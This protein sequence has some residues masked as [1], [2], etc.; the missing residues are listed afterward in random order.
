MSVASDKKVITL[1]C[2]RACDLS[3]VT[4][5]SG[6]VKDVS[7]LHV[8]KLPCSGMIQP[9]MIEA[10]MKAGAAGVIVTGCQIGDCY[11]RE[12]NRMIRD[13][14]LGNRPPGLKKTVDRRRVLALWLARPQK[15][16]FLSEA[17]EFVQMV[18][19]LSDDKPAAAVAPKPEAKAEAK[20]EAKAEA[21]KTEEKASE[22]T[23]ES[24][25]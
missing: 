21:K 15:D 25:E 23:S 13:R 17:K 10:A 1:I 18:R 12:G 22:S 5:A 6:E 14:L 11:Y 9:L 4:E 16:R 2:E 24:K 20:V 7:G 3:S 8:V 19:N